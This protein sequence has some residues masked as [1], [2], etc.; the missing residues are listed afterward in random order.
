M[1]RPTTRL[2]A[3]L[4]ATGLAA[5]ALAACTGGTEQ[6][7]SASGSASSGS[8]SATP[9]PTSSTEQILAV[10]CD[11]AAPESVKAIK[12]ALKPDFTVTQLVDVFSEDP[13]T[14][15]ILGFVEGPGLAVL[16]VWTGKGIALEGLASTD[17]FAAEASTAPRV[18]PD[19]E[20]GKLIGQTTSCYTSLV[21]PG[22][23]GDDKDTDKKK[24]KKKDKDNG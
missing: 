19:E 18:T 6:S 10:V 17:D 23:D 8:A 1:T 11:K 9:A 3:A 15:A 4:A 22:G 14:H 20:L 24:D 5:T 21:N 12:A 16:A 7:T 2:I 13:G